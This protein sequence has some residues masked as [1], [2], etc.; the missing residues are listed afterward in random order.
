MTQ[1]DAIQPPA[2]AK[3]QLPTRSEITAE[4]QGAI[5]HVSEYLGQVSQLVTKHAITEV[6][7]MGMPDPKIAGY[8]N[9]WRE[10]IPG[11]HA[12]IV[13]KW[14][15]TD[16]PC[17]GGIVNVRVWAGSILWPKTGERVLYWRAMPDHLRRV[18]LFMA[19]DQV[20]LVR[21]KPDQPRHRLDHAL[22]VHATIEEIRD[23][24]IAAWWSDEPVSPLLAYD[25]MSREN[26]GVEDT[27]LMVEDLKR[28]LIAYYAH[29]T[30]HDPLLVGLQIDCSHREHDSASCGAFCSDLKSLMS[31]V[32]G[33]L[34]A[35]TAESHVHTHGQ[36]TLELSDG[37]ADQEDGPQ[38][39][40]R[41]APAVR[42]AIMR[43]VT[44]GEGM[45]PPIQTTP[46]LTPKQRR[47]RRKVVLGEMR[48]HFGNEY[49]LASKSFSL[50]ARV[51]YFLL[52]AVVAGA[53]WP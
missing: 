28:G 34:A 41:L 39:T 5:D 40:D 43:P 23:R 7:F 6:R 53:L 36:P 1:H 52:G 2:A 29:R 25:P 31:P 9:R 30:A 14:F 15:D 33:Y 24:Q 44:G 4:L 42:D 27:T 38:P 19:V 26:I 21:R 46:S 50:A 12:A 51:L 13:Y 37:G 3:L 49:H 35:A 17:S 8:G 18:Q 48:K 45:V 22:D 16:V 47:V 11:S 32:L 10:V 20:A